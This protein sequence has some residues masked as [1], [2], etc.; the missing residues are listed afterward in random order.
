[1][2]RYLIYLLLGRHSC[3]ACHQYVA[4]ADALLSLLRAKSEAN[5]TGS[6]GRCWA[7]SY[8]AV[9]AFNPSADSEHA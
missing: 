2:W 1:M 7:D 6:I 3:A 8:T 5:Q 4:A 9:S